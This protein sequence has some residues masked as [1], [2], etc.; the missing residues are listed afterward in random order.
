MHKTEAYISSMLML[1]TVMLDTT[2]HS[3]SLIITARVLSTG[4]E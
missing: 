3:S 1:C 2:A 4:R